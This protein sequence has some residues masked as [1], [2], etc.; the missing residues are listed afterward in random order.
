MGWR[1]CCLAVG[2]LLA[3]GCG[4]RLKPFMTETEEHQ[5]QAVA[6]GAGEF[7]IDPK[8]GRPGFRF[9][10]A[11]GEYERGHE[12]GAKYVLDYA[13]KLGI[14]IDG[15]IA[16]EKSAPLPTPAPDPMPPP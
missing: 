14:A 12:D 5:I 11:K 7:K 2:V 15:P 3:S 6:E 9:L 4:F 13:K 1:V 8:S 16:I 10:N